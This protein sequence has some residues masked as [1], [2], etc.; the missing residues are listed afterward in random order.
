MKNSKIKQSLFFVFFINLLLIFASSLFCQS[1]L[2]WEDNFDGTSVDTSKWE[3]LDEA[4]GSDSWYRPENIAVSDGTLKLYNKEELYNGKH[5]TG[6]HIDALYYPQ[7]KYLEA[8]VKHSSADTYIW[9]AWWT[10]GWASNTWHWPPEFDICEFQGGGS[11]K[12]PGQWYH[13]LNGSGNHTWT[14]SDTGMDETQW[15]TYGIYWDDSNSPVFYV[16]GSVSNIPGLGS[17]EPPAMGAK[18]KLTSSPNSMNRFSGCALGTMEVDWVRVYDEPPGGSPYTGQVPV[19]EITNPLPDAVLS[20]TITATVNAYDPDTGTNNGDGIS[21]IKFQLLNGTSV[22]D[23]KQDTILPYSWNLDTTLYPNGSYTLQAR[24][25]DGLLSA[26]TSIPITINNTVPTPTP[27]ASITPNPAGNNLLEN[28]S[29]S[30]SNGWSGPVIMG[31]YTTNCIYDFSYTSDAPSVGT[32]PCLRITTNVSANSAIYQPVILTGGETY[33]FD[34]AVKEP[35]IPGSSNFWIE[36]YLSPTQPTGTDITSSNSQA[37]GYCKWENWVPNYIN[38]YNGLL[39]NLPSPLSASPFTVPGTGERIYYF[40]IKSGITSGG[41]LDFL[42]DNMVL[43]KEGAFTPTPSPSPTPTETSSQNLIINGDFSAGSTGWTLI[44]DSGLDGFISIDC[45]YNDDSPI[46]GVTPGLRLYAD[47]TDSSI[48]GTSL[49]YQPIELQGGNAYQLN[50]SIKLRDS[51]NTYWVEFMLGDIEPILGEIYDPMTYPSVIGIAGLMNPSWGG[52][53]SYNGLITELPNNINNPFIAPGTGIK[54]YY[55][56]IRGGVGPNSKLDVIIDNLTLT[57]YTETNTPTPTPSETIVPTNTPL[58]IGFETKL[59]ASDQRANDELGHSVSISGNTAIIGAPN[60]IYDIIYDPGSVYIFEKAN[61]IWTQTTKLTP[62]DIAYHDFFGRF[63]SISG[64]DAIV[65]VDYD[66]DNGSDSGSAYIFEKINGIWIQTGKLLASNGEH[67]DSF[68]GSVSISGDTAVIGAV[69]NDDYGYCAGS[70]YVFE[71]VNG[72]WTQTKQ[73]NPSDEVAGDYFGYSVSISGDTIIVG[74]NVNSEYIFERENGIWVEKAK[75]V[76]NNNNMG[77]RFGSSSSI[78]GN[79]VIIGSMWDNDFGYQ[80]GSAYIFEKIN[81]T[82]S[83]TAELLASDG[84]NEDLFGSSVSLSGNTAVVGSYRDYNNG[85]HTGS[86]YVFEKRDGVWS[87]KA[88]LRASDGEDFDYFGF[89]VAISGNTIMSGAPW[90]DDIGDL[91]GVVYVFD[92]SLLNTPTPTPDQTVFNFETDEEGCESGGAPNSYTEPIFDYQAGNIIMQSTDYHTYGYWETSHDSIGYLPDCIYKATFSVMGSTPAEFAPELRLR[93]NT[94]SATVIGLSDYQSWLD[95]GES[96]SSEGYRNYEMYFD[97]MDQTTYQ[98]MSNADNIFAAVEMISFNPDDNNGAFYIDS[99]VIDRIPLFD[100]LI[101]APITVQ[102]YDTTEDF[103]TWVFEGAP[104]FFTLPNS[105]IGD[106]SLTLTA[107]NDNTSTYGYWA[108]S[109]VL[110]DVDIIRGING[111][112]D[113]YR[114]VFTVSS[115]TP[116]AQCPTIR[117]RFGTESNK[118]TSLVVVNSNLDGINSPTPEGKQYC[119]YMIPPASDLEGTEDVNGL[120]VGMDLINI[121]NTDALDANATL[122]KVEIQEINFIDE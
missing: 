12:T 48:W 40:V 74:T 23:Y 88:K 3:I 109:R 6:G 41:T 90:D 42:L 47:Y 18:L 11:N 13:Y 102:T 78:S 66:D 86:A 80:S 28:S 37:M 118:M 56:V 46:Y 89:S 94:E 87:Q 61:G 14:G 55:L 76:P 33:T 9:S 8:R 81:G 95:G 26:T 70:A 71:K 121:F 62:S 67:G 68:G 117:L 116:Q 92:L 43:Q 25:S 39:S 36:F 82:W 110:N 4:D 24:A 72:T 111:L 60:D 119:V 16:D 103:S 53:D 65:G 97:P 2:L 79:T 27:V 21:L 51:I 17:G 107:N 99:I 22:L 59:F 57:E 34:T 58:P 91:S 1:N 31:A 104:D 52:P 54:T 114:A 19:V 69:Q 75:L 100:D 105:S 49:I 84:S 35:S 113:L 115:T 20:G 93:L 98:S 64:D 112:P 108:S 96:P 120:I 29:F 38:N 10:V 5:W 44:S 122:E 85:Y 73:L 32:T 83:Q 30:S 15:H 7:Y 45:N 63:V 106:G 50:G 101:E 77:N